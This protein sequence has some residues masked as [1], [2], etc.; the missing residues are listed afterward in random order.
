MAARAF[1]FSTPS[2]PTLDDAGHLARID[3][4]ADGKSDILV[5]ERRRRERHP[6]SI[7]E[8]SKPMSACRAG[9]SVKLDRYRAKP[10]T[11]ESGFFTHGS[12]GGTRTPDPR[13]M[14]PVL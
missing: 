11:I 3:E 9:R 10:A 2:F 4:G 7:S 13:I 1:M 14:I 12:G 8:V 5:G 6:P